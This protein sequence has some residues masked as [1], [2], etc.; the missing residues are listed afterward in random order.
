[1]K[2]KS[3]PVCMYVC[4]YM[5][6]HEVGGDGV[7]L[8]HE[9][10][11]GRRLDEHALEPV[12][13]LGGRLHLVPERR[14]DRQV[15]EEQRPLALEVLELTQLPRLVVQPPPVLQAHAHWT[16]YSTSNTAPHRL[17][18]LRAL[19]DYRFTI[20]NNRLDSSNVT[21]REGPGLVG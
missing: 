13:V 20:Q 1:M 6:A 8:G 2:S 10:Q 7:E 17:A 14:V 11:V 3:V 5:R 9:V 12:E 18:V 16:V 19:F 21:R 4:M 15:R